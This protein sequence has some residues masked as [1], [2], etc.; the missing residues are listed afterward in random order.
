M[1]LQKTL[2]EMAEEIKRYK[3]HII[4]T[5]AALFFLSL[6]VALCRSSPSS[7]RSAELPDL[8]QSVERMDPASDIITR[9]MIPDIEAVQ[10]EMAPN[11]FLGRRVGDNIYNLPRREYELAEEDLFR[12]HAVPE[13]DA[14]RAADTPVESSG[15][16]TDQRSADEY[17]VEF[18]FQSRETPAKRDYEDE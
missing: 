4:V 14:D 11:S 16:D 5:A 9:V 13:K 15:V 7:D 17:E 10:P 6:T 12:K 2:Q 3:L 1:D 18:L 8:P